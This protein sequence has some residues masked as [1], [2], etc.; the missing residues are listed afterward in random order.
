[1]YAF[2]SSSSER[3]EVNVD[4]SLFLS[5]A[6]PRAAAE[7]GAGVVATYPNM[8]SFI[9]TQPRKGTNEEKTESNN[10]KEEYSKRSR[11]RRVLLN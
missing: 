11:L 2:S 9:V 3:E 5:T 8:R 4:T 10:K 7:A 1:M 6:A